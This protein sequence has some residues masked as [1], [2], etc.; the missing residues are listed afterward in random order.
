MALLASF[1][2]PVT[3]WAQSDTKAEKAEIVFDISKGSVVFGGTYNGSYGYDGYNSSGT[4]IHGAHNDNNIYVITGSVTSTCT[5]AYDAATGKHSISAVQNPYTV[6]IE[7]VNLVPSSNNAGRKYQITLRNL[8]IDRSKVDICTYWHYGFNESGVGNIKPNFGV[9]LSGGLYSDTPTNIQTVRYQY[10][11]NRSNSRPP[12]DAGDDTVEVILTLE[13]T[14]TLKGESG[15]N[16]AL[17][18][19]R[20]DGA[21]GAGVNHWRGVLGQKSLTIKGSGSLTLKKDGAQNAGAA[22]GA[23]A[24]GAGAGSVASGKLII[25]GGTILAETGGP[26][27]YSIPLGQELGNY[28]GIIGH[29]SQFGSFAAAIG[30]GACGRCGDIIIKGGTVT[31]RAYATCPAIGAGGGFLS[32]GGALITEIDGEEVSGTITIEGASTVVNAYSMGMMGSIASVEAATCIGGGSCNFNSGANAGKP[33]QGAE[34]AKI[35]IKGGTINAY[36][37]A[38]NDGTIEYVRGDIGGGHSNTSLSMP[39]VFSDYWGSA[40]SIT[41][42]NGGDANVKITGGT[43]YAANIGG[44]CATHPGTE[45]I[46]TK[47]GDAL[48]TIDMTSGLVDLTGF[49]GGGNSVYKSG[50][51]ATV[52]VVKGTIN[53]GSIGGGNSVGDD[54]ASPAVPGDGNGG[55]ATV[56]VQGGKLTVTGKIGGGYSHGAGAGGNASII[57][58]GGELDCASIGGG[59]TGTGTPGA[60]ASTSGAGVQI[61]GAS[62][63]V[64]TGFVGGGTNAA[65]TAFGKA[66]ASVAGGSIQG[67]FILVNPSSTVS[68]Y[69]YFTMTGG[70][71]DNTHLGN[72]GAAS[73]ARKMAQGGAVYMQDANGSVSISGGTIQNC[74]GTLG[75][76]IYMTN[77]TFTLSGTGSITNCKAK[78]I[79]A[80]QDRTDYNGGAVYMGGGV[81]NIQGGSISYNEATTNGGGIYANAGTTTITKGSIEY[82]EATN[83]GGIYANG[84]TVTINY[85]STSDGTINHNYASE[86]GGGL[87]IPANGSLYLKGQTTLEYNHV[88]IRKQGGGVYLEGMVQAGENSSTTIVVEKNYAGDTYQY[89]PANNLNNRNNIYLPIPT[90]V[91]S[92][93]VAKDV[94][95]VVNGGLNLT[96]TKIGFSVPHNFVPVIYCSN[97]Y[98][99]SSSIMSSDAVFEDG[100]RYQK[101]YS[102][103]SPYNAN[104]IYL[105]AN[106]WAYAVAANPDAPNAF[107]YSNINTPQK[108]AW[109]ISLVNGLHGQ[110]PDN[111]SGK[112]IKITADLDMKAYSWVPI[113]MTKDVSGTPTEMPFKGTFN[114]NGHII[115]NIYCSYLGNDDTGTGANLGLFGTVENAIIHDVFLNGVELQVLNQTEGSFGMGAIASKSKGTTMIYNCTADSKMESSWRTTTMGGLVAE[116]TG[117]TIHSSAAMPEMVGY[118]M[119]GLAGTNGG[120]IY[121]SFANPQFEYSGSGTEYVGGLVAQNTGL[122]KNCY[123][124]LERTQSL[125]SARFGMLAGRNTDGSTNGS[126]TKCY[127]PDKS[128]SQFNLPSTY[129]YLY[130]NDATGLTDCNVYSKVV[131]PY[132]YA[133]NPSTDNVVGSTPLLEMLNNNREGRAEWKRTTAGGYVSTYSEGSS[134]VTSTGGDING[135]YPIHKLSTNG[136]NTYTCVAST[137]GINLD[138]AY[139]L[140]GMLTRHTAIATVNLYR[141]ES[142]VTESTL[143]NVV[144][145]IDED[146]S[147]LQGNTSSS[148][149]AYTGQTLKSYGGVRWHNFSSPL[150]Q[151]Y[152]GFDYSESHYATFNWDSNPCDISLSGDNDNALFPSDMPDIR[153]I[154]LYCFYE[155]EYHWI[156]FKRRTD[157]H[158][159]MNATETPINYNGNGIRPNDPNDPD[160]PSNGNETYLVP[161]KGYLVSVDKEQFLQN[162]GV[163]NNGNVVLCNV[164]KTDYNAWA[165]RLG[166]NLLGNPYQSY[167]DFEAFMD[168]DLGDGKTNAGYLWDSESDFSE[169]CRTFAIFDPSKNSYVQYKNGTSYDSYGATQYIHPHQGFFIRMTKGTNSSIT[170][171]YKNAMRV[172]GDGG[173]F[174]DEERPAYPLVNFLVRDSEGNGDVAVLELGRTN[175]EGALKMRL[176]DCTGKI[177]LGYEG[178]EYGILFRT[179]VG[180]YQPLHFDATEAGVFTLTW[181]TANGEF[182]ALTLIDNIAGTT[183]D[184]LN[185]DSYTFEATPDQY[186]SRFKIVIGD[187]KDIEEHEGDGPST[188]SGTEGTATFA[189]YADGEIRLAETCHGAPLQII[190]MMGRVIVSKDASNASAISTDG[191]APGVYMLRLTNENGT[192][193]Q[194]IVIR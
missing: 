140:D 177:S 152:T 72:I 128:V 138:Y 192:K 115:S 47:G 90:D 52:N 17:Q 31:A 100:E 71:L 36:K 111:F 53:A 88:P 194:K 95:T 134:T 8:T 43:I 120:N 161:G 151:S 86:K 125:G 92:G 55:T 98:Y 66:T 156:N 121:N 173:T 67:Q 164:T 155:P 153:N 162:K 108:L 46:D 87:Y 168:T 4:R 97:P 80:K 84:G 19:H 135:D 56:N 62:T 165:E 54:T 82:N 119:G 114:G 65:G 118:T 9:A 27:E 25:E 83:G 85:G 21:V 103:A 106:T 2:F 160:D 96:D 116:L 112:E 57:V 11:N 99:L 93:G 189:Y 174:R 104:Y 157:S 23:A 182:E 175:D 42:G 180:D 58:T 22:L 131:A 158:W 89:N 74:T 148:I 14:N 76:A 39:A 45:L 188:G 101:Y 169:Y 178:E 59:D 113:G 34:K 191:I 126:I 139:S 51:D 5:Q 33:A 179:E 1:S 91:L 40:L 20:Y 172:L 7:T 147:L 190:D 35:I 141:N 64:K 143:N 6:T 186:A 13:G 149:T 3:A 12:F 26:G 129:Y 122:V 142:N 185:H 10:N 73:Y 181:N 132:L 130:N 159:H 136:S 193:T 110:T 16:A 48:L 77:G 41:P 61:S 124:R 170:V 184:M 127:A 109:L 24:L 176:G 28:H 105:S 70:T 60:V 187:Y 30:G 133:H 146:V 18:Y 79:T 167:L 78:D 68:D 69:S 117:G 75:G 29:P 38:K 123:V 145:Y 37:N 50:G 49:I 32:A 154:D 137:D 15:P 81:C 44:G 171:T 63:I 183:T 94:I 144:V 102:T 163:L 107:D 150:K 166:F